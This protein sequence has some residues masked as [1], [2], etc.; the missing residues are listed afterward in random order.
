MKEKCEQSMEG[1]GSQDDGEEADSRPIGHDFAAAGDDAF[2]TAD[3]AGIDIPTDPVAD[4]SAD[5]HAA[6]G[7]S[8]NAAAAASAGSPS[9]AALPRGRR[10]ILPDANAEEI[11]R[12]L[13]RDASKKRRSQGGPVSASSSCIELFERMAKSREMKQQQV[14]HVQERQLELQEEYTKMLREQW[15]WSRTK[16]ENQIMLMDL[17][18]CSDAARQYFSILQQEI[19][20]KR[21]NRG[22]LGGG[23]SGSM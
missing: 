20:Q 9:P 13:G 19:L 12:P 10:S 21:L 23:P 16:E 1:E 15:D 17:D 14:M 22:G 3:Y 5:A 4:A 8:P 11:P 6:A 7:A 18:A 2:P